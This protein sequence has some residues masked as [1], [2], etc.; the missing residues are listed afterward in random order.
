MNMKK[1]L[2]VI[3]SFLPMGILTAQEISIDDLIAKYLVAIGQ[4]KMANIQTI[5]ET[6]KALMGKIELPITTILKRPDLWRTEGDVQGT[7]IIL[8]GNGQSGWLLDPTK[9][10]SE[11]QDMPAP[12]FNTA[13]KSMRR[14]PYFNW[15]NPFVN[16]KEKGNKLELAGKEVLKET[17]VYNIKLTFKDGEEVNYY[18]DA[19]KFII[20]KIK[21]KSTLRKKTSDEEEILSDFRSVD[22]ILFPFKNESFTNGQLTETDIGEKIEFNVRVFDMLFK[23]PVVNK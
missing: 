8:A 13:I 3:F 19:D 2:I 6:G 16:W 18:M 22:G 17:Q 5:T 12:E 23:K 4:D 1:L 7:M 9:G 21:Y 14:D 11:P 20:I 10:S 15:N